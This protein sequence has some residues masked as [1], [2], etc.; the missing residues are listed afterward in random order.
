MGQRKTFTV[1]KIEGFER[2]IVFD[3]GVGDNEYSSALT[4]TVLYESFGC[5]NSQVARSLST[6]PQRQYEMR[7]R[8]NPLHQLSV[9]HQGLESLVGADKRRVSVGGIDEGQALERC[10]H[11]EPILTS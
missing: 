7:K 6:W 4:F 1:F 5:E 2:R 10:I 9:D 3:R 11:F 8:M